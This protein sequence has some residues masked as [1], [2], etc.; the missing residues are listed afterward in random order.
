MATRLNP[1]TDTPNKKS[2]ITKD[3]MLGY[4]RFKGTEE[5]REWFKA[6]VNKNVKEKSDESGATTEAENNKTSTGKEIDLKKI[7]SE[8]CQR[9]FPHLE[10]P[11][12]AD[13]WL[14]DVESL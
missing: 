9:F 2:Q 6:V 4:I 14:M 8:F 7:R 10:N 11:T 5:D 13:L 3:F 12:Q 1:R